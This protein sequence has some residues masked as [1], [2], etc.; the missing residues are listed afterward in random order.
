[1]LLSGMLRSFALLTF[2]IVWMTP[3]A[4]ADEGFE[5]FSDV[6][7]ET[8]TDTVHV[9]G[10]EIQVRTSFVAARK[11]GA[12]I[13]PLITQ[14]ATYENGDVLIDRQVGEKFIDD[15]VPC[16]L[17]YE[18]AHHQLVRD[19]ATAPVASGAGDLAYKTEIDEAR[20][21]LEDLDACEARADAWRFTE[22]LK[23]MTLE[24]LDDLIDE[25]PR[26]FYMKEGAYLGQIM[27][28][29]VRRRRL[30]PILEGGC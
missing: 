30:V 17:W 2:A 18:E 27:L 23:S 8:F 29:D 11:G 10:E 5:P 16:E 28:F 26:V 19:L 15:E 13:W 14:I 24:Q 21:C 6:C 12:S 20:E 25:K 1:M 3:L 22:N 9:A 7:N 4:M